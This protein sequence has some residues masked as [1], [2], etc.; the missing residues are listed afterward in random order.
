[1]SIFRPSPLCASIFDYYGLRVYIASMEHNRIRKV[2]M[3]IV[4]KYPP[5]K[6]GGEKR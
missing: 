1:M 5:E 3:K 2:M 6:T 4:D